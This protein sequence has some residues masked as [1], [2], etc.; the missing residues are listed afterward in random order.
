MEAAKRQGRGKPMKTEQSEAK[1]RSEDRSEDF[2]QN[3]A[4]A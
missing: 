2:R 1:A 3:G 4:P